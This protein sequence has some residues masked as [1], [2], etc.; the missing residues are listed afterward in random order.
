MKHDLWMLHAPVPREEELW[1]HIDALWT[2]LEPHTEYLLALKSRAQVDV[3][4]SYSSHIDHAGLSV[5]PAS[6]A[7][8]TALQL[9]FALS[10]VV[11]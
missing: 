5:P 8:F 3:W 6:L 10:I 11:L 1:R 9:D 7:M 2:L 4:L